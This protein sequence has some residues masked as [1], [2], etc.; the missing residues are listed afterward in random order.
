MIL[1]N[2]SFIFNELLKDR[3]IYSVLGASAVAGSVTRTVSVVMIV[4]E[5]NGHLSHAVPLMIC[6][7]CSYA[8]S[9]FLKPES[10]FEM[11]ANFTEL[12]K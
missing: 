3:G 12:D 11:L 4:I 5:L 1:F 7:L 9:E 8:T 2:V 10:F 6:V